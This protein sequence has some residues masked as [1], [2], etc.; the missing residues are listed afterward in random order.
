[1]ASKYKQFNP[2]DRPF[3]VASGDIRP[4]VRLTSKA[5]PAIMNSELV[6]MQADI[7][8]RRNDEAS[9]QDRRYAD[10]RTN[11]LLGVTDDQ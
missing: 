7:R 4:T 10:P 9:G 2:D 5:I 11:A 1:M 6:D 8:A 3:T